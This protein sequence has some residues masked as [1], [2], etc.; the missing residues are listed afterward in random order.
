MIGTPILS[1]ASTKIMDMCISVVAAIKSNYSVAK[2]RE[3]ERDGRGGGGGG[4]D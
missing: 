4:G 2:E 3:R 1:M